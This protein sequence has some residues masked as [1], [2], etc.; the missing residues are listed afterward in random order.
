MQRRLDAS[1]WIHT[2]SNYTLQLRYNVLQTYTSNFT[3]FY[4]F[5]ETEFRESR[6]FSPGVNSPSGGQGALRDTLG[7]RQR[8][9]RH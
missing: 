4:H 5:F 2:V 1:N 3:V 8:L 7:Y 9:C 6:R